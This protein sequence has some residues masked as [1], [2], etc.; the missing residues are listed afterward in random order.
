MK[1]ANK[2]LKKEGKYKN[3]KEKDVERIMEDT[4][5]F[6]FG[7]D[8]TRRSRRICSS[9]TKRWKSWNGRRRYFKISYE[10]F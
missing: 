10:I 9:F 5:D 7:R 3:L 2:V 1:E 4:N 8:I 6:I